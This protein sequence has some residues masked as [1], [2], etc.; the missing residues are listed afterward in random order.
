MKNR[1]RYVVSFNGYWG[2]FRRAFPRRGKRF[3]GPVIFD[4]GHPYRK[5]SISS[6]GGLDYALVGINKAFTHEDWL[7]L[8]KKQRTSLGK[9]VFKLEMK[10]EIGK[11]WG[12][13][14]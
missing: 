2:V 3:R 12:K 11:T 1:L 5:Y 8:G 4:E 10:K 7:R 6:P 9:L 14:E 13:P